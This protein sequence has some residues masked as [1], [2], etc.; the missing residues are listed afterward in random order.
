MIKA[1]LPIVI[2]TIASI[3]RSVPPAPEADNKMNILTEWEMQNEKYLVRGRD[4]RIEN[5]EVRA[6]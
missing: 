2:P 1:A 4:I 6:S 3:D 5:I